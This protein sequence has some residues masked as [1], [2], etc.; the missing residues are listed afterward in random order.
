MHWH[1]GRWRSERV[2]ELQ[3]AGSF[4]FL[5][6]A[7]CP[8]AQRG[9]AERVAPWLDIEA[10][11]DSFSILSTWVDLVVVNALG[12]PDRQREGGTGGASGMAG[13]AQALDLPVVIA[14]EDGQRGL[15]DACHLVARLRARGLRIV[16]WVQSGGPPMACATGLSCLG[17]IPSDALRDPAQAARHV[18]VARLLAL[19]TPGPGGRAPGASV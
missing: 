2:I 9:P 15:H 16:A 18:D 6:S 12:A 14:C 7:L 3:G 1:L 13:V 8:S 5:V 4:G 17:A 19:L 10:L 11:V